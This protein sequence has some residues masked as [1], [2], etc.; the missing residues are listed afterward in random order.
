MVRSWPEAA[1]NRGLARPSARTVEGRPVA[2]SG[3]D[4]NENRDG[5]PHRPVEPDGSG[6]ASASAGVTSFA[7]RTVWRAIIASSSVCIT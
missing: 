5:E 2:R 1:R 6:Q 3:L 7:T 4:R